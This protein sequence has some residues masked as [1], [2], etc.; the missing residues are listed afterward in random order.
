MDC[1]RFCL[2]HSSRPSALTAYPLIHIDPNRFHTILGRTTMKQQEPKS[3]C[4][5]Y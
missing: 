3:K 5:A 2:T 4:F 1:S